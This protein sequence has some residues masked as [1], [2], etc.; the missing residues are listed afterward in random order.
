MAALDTAFAAAPFERTTAVVR[1]CIALTRPDTAVVT[2]AIA[3]LI[4]EDVEAAEL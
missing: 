3:V 1:V 4:S 2:A